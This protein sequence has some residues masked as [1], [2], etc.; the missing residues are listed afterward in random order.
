M[1]K[2]SATVLLSMFIPSFI[3]TGVCL[4]KQDYKKS[5]VSLTLFY[6]NMTFLVHIFAIFNSPAALFCLSLI[7]LFTLLNSNIKVLNTADTYYIL[8]TIFAW[9][10]AKTILILPTIFFLIPIRISFIITLFLLY[11]FRSFK[12]PYL[13]VIMPILMY[14]VCLTAVC[15]LF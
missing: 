14:Y 12:L 15:I 8:I 2:F 13:V 11:K 5:R 10:S 1:D 7:L 4:M 3:I 9:L 6:F